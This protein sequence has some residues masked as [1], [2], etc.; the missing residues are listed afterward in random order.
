M[1]KVGCQAFFGIGFNRK[2]EKWIVKEFKG[3]HNHLLV[4]AIDTQFL[5]S[6]WVVSNSD[7]AQVNVMHKVG[8]KTC[9]IMD[10]MVLERHEHVGFTPKDIHNHVD[11][12]HKIEL[13]MMM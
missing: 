4:D 13:T 12:M 1:A 2:L 7:K 8:V 3:D 11:V 6:H 9:Q 5:R 10:Y